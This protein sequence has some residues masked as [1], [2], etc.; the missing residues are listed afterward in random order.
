MMVLVVVQDPTSYY[1][2]QVVS[3]LFPSGQG[4][5]IISRVLLPFA[6]QQG[7]ASK[8]STRFARLRAEDGGLSSQPW[9]SWAPLVGAVPA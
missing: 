6:E 2:A 4:L 7:A 1:D 9:R 5:R 8:A 3:T